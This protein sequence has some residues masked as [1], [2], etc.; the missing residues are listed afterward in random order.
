[1]IG[2]G[3]GVIKSLL[4][5]SDEAIPFFT[6]G[7]VMDT[8][9]PAQM[10]RARVRCGKYGDKATQDM[11]DLP[12]ALPV[13]PLAGVITHGMR[14]SEQESVNAPVAYG[15]WN[16]P[17]IGSYVIVGCIDGDKSKRFYV[18]G[19]HPQYLVNT[20]PHGRFIWRKA[21][22]EGARPDGPLSSDEVPIEPLYSN[23][24]EQFTLPS[25]EGTLT[26]R[27]PGTPNKPRVGNA[28]Y[29]SRGAD[30]Q[31][32][33]LD[34]TLHNDPRNSP[35]NT[36]V[37]HVPGEAIHFP[38][39]DGT[40]RSILGPGY[41]IDQIEPTEQY[42][43]ETAQVNYDS[44]NYSWTTPGFHSL[45]MN[46]RYDQC[47][48]RIRTTSGHQILM[49][50]T[51]ERIYVSTAGG[52]SYIEIDKLGNIDI[53]AEKTISTHAKGD[54]NFYSDKS[55]RL[56][57]VE[58]IHMR[59][60]RE[61]RQHSLQDFHVRSEMNIRTHSKLETKI[62]ADT[63]MDIRVGVGSGNGT[64]YIQSQN[65]FNMTSTSGEM[66]MK[67]SA[68]MSLKSGASIAGDAPTIHWN[69]AHANDAIEAGEAEEKQAWWTT[70]VPDH[71][72]WA[73]VFMDPAFSDTDENNAHE[74]E[75]EYTDEMVGRGS[76][77]RGDV[78]VRGPW[79]QR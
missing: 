55:I 18:G 26:R 34:K 75:Y 47:R 57:A 27:A 76:E 42:G 79:W 7:K 56:Q 46:D 22:S 66:R 53:F 11:V 28:E 32:S 60:D 50:D 61:I 39:A 3:F 78:Y 54:I 36:T 77:T 49:D 64:L 74:P 10:G 8:N 30:M 20:L 45:S 35:G 24:T 9:D 21:D 19:V 73:R 2:E 40:T 14:G 13:S 17:K 25:G 33:A 23:M 59:A 58:D 62:E 68:L 16:I 72:P 48:I 4:F 52:Q 29:E 70:R 6:V 69:S 12:W 1:M 37:D 71:E 43:P 65:D 31:A 41:S 67:S 63:N 15:M 5:D 38:K 44:H 51:N